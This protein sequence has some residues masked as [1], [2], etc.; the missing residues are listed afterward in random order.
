MIIKS[1]EYLIFCLCSIILARY[2]EKKSR[3]IAIAH[4][5]LFIALSMAFFFATDNKNVVN[6]VLKIVDKDIYNT[7]HVALVESQTYINIGFSTFFIIEAI[8]F[9]TIALAAVIVFIKSLKEEA[10][11]IRIKTL[12]NIKLLS[13]ILKKEEEHSTYII[14]R[15]E[16]KHLLNCKFQN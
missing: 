6:I 12:N 3:V 9:T 7:I 15:T 10:K 2:I 4:D 16:N 8:I 11:K 5:I 1:M 13:S 14:P